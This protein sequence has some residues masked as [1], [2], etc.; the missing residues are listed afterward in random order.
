MMDELRECPFCPGGGRPVVGKWEEQG[1]GG[2]YNFTS[3]VSCLDCLSHG[4]VMAG[5]S[6]VT[7]VASAVAAWNKRAEVNPDT[8][9][10]FGAKSYRNGYANGYKDALEQRAELTCNN[11]LKDR[12]YA[13]VFFKCSECGFPKSE[14]FEDQWLSKEVNFCP[15]CGRKVVE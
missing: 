12:P 15:N 1:W 5:V 14:S 9:T 3:Q 7:A 8:A 6:E 10:A 2:E 11:V 13:K 4:P